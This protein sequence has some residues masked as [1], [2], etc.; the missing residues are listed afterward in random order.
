MLKRVSSR[1]KSNHQRGYRLR[2]TI[3]SPVAPANPLDTSPRTIAIGM[4]VTSRKN[5]VSRLSPSG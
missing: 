5:V 1:A 4:I 2:N 3:I